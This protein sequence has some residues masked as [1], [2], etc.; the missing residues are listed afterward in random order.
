MPVPSVPRRAL[1]PRKKTPKTPSTPAMPEPAPEPTSSL[2][3]TNV[4]GASVHV[5]PSAYGGESSVTEAQATAS[6][7]RQEEVGNV[8]ASAEDYFDHS[9]ALAHDRPAVVATAST[10]IHDDPIAE[11]DVAEAE[12]ATSP[13]S[14]A[15]P[16][17]PDDPEVYLKPK[18]DIEPEPAHDPELAVEPLTPLADAPSED[19]A[20][21]GQRSD[22]VEDE[23]DEAARRQRI[24]QRLAQMGGVNP[25][26]A[27]RE[28]SPEH[29]ETGDVPRKSSLEAAP[30]NRD[31][32]VP[33]H[34]FEPT[35][36]PSE[37]RGSTEG[38]G[39][40]RKTVGDE[41]TEDGEY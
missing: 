36:T 39:L 23:E 26:S 16:E 31:S 30:G 38:V 33:V 34:N 9:V 2:E 5:S 27:P 41:I 1:P 40:V 12:R 35:S 8:N 15:R 13:S 29:E 3:P 14:D 7:D 6:G 37:P 11:D 17:S 28:P 19:P 4:L 10:E 24:A 20:G 25:L 21:E 22:E 18:R 32:N